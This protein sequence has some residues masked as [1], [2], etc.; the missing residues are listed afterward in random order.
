MRYY[1][2]SLYMAPARRMARIFSETKIGASKVMSDSAGYDVHTYLIKKQVSFLRGSS[3]NY[4]LVM[5]I[6]RDLHV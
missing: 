1:Y 6:A 2:R 5:S 3:P 4:W